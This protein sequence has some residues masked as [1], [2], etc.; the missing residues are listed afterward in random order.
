MSERHLTFTTLVAV[1][2]AG[3]W[4]VLAGD[5]GAQTRAKPGTASRATGPHT[6]WG[7]PDL[8]GVWTNSTTTPLERPDKFAD[9]AT[10]TDEERATLDAD[11]VRNADRPPAKGQTGA[12]NDFWFDKGKRS[13]QTSLVIDPP[14]G[15]LP[16]MT[17][18]GRKLQT[19]IAQVR[20]NPPA[21]PEDLSLF[22]RCITRSLP[23]AML[24]G[25]YNH[26]YQI[27]QSPGYV[28]ILV[29]MIHDVRIIPTD[30]RPHAGPAIQ[31]W[32]GDSRG[33]WEGNTLVVETTNVRPAREIR[34][35][36]TV[37][38]GSEKLKVIERFTR[39]GADRMDYQFT[40]TD[41]DSFTGP[42]TASTPMS[43]I[44]APIYEYACHEGNHSIEN[45]LRGAR[46]HEQ[47]AEEAAKR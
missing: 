4:L 25:F 40:V 5:A 44:D 28:A 7:D 12:Y 43:K 16:A 37:F 10:L 47:E 2:A 17:P 13:T 6:P 21:V 29:E 18:D 46:Q 22:E 11:D 38:G 24:P 33:R 41:P 45:M 27:L 26:N 39:V 32:L 31:R 9:K 15:K 19:A 35:S 1:G 8:Q 3:V 30:G 34:A 14:T 23:G 36:R 42:W 20:Q